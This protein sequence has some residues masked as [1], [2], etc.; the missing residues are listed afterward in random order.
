MAAGDNL[1]FGASGEEGLGGDDEDLLMLQKAVQNALDKK[2]QAVVKKQ[3]AVLEEARAGAQK[4]VAAL[5]AMIV[6]V[7]GVVCVRRVRRAGSAEAEAEGSDGVR[8]SAI[9]VACVC[10]GF[11]LWGR[12]CGGRPAVL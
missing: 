12:A 2:K 9:W 1:D 5:E 8:G 4:R 10:V 6:K 7:C 11:G 3:A